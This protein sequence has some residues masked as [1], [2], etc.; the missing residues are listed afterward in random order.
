[1]VDRLKTSLENLEPPEC[2]HCHIE[3]KWFESKLIEP[4]PAAVIEHQFACDTCGRTRKFRE[5]VAT[6]KKGRPTRL[7]RSPH[8]ARAA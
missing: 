5:K 3:M 8:A 2:P 6:E 7:P 1:M 4:E